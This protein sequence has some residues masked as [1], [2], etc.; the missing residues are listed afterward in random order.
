MALSLIKPFSAR[1]HP[2]AAQVCKVLE[3]LIEALRDSGEGFQQASEQAS[4]HELKVELAA[5][6]RQ[7]ALFIK[8]LQSIQRL[9]GEVRV[10]RP[11]TAGGMLHRAWDRLKACVHEPEDAEI[12]AEAADAEREIAEKFE[13]ALAG[14]SGLPQDVSLC[15]S[16]QCAE[17][18]K[19]HLEL[20]GRRLPVDSPAPSATPGSF[21]S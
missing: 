19:G 7:R 14:K 1:A 9:Y 13:D 6:G 18:Q 17:L 15:L 21:H 5:Y 3:R 4:N 16:R 11:G 20:S 8:E 12:L 2:P 10:D